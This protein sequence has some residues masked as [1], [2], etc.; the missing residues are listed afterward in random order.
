MYTL[1]GS[2][3]SNDGATIMKMLEIVHPAARILCDISLAQDA[4][5]GDGT[6]T[7]V[8]LAGELLKEAKPYIEEGVH[9]QLLIKA[10][11]QAAQ[12]AVEYVKGGAINL[13]DKPRDELRGLLEKCAQTSLNSKLVRENP[14]WEK[15]HPMHTTPFQV[16]GER[17]FFASM[18]VDAVYKLDPVM[19]D[20]KYIGTSLMFLLLADLVTVLLLPR[21]LVVRFQPSRCSLLLLLLSSSC[22]TRTSRRHQEGSGRQPA[23]QLPRRRR[24]VQED[25]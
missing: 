11:R 19:L 5:V 13:E 9:P 24:C 6:T 8:I 3:I 14:A 23:R 15:T 7:V 20:L 1:Q 17:D 10:Y 25:L 16:S 12:L 22:L 21:D 4:E 2:T 18:V